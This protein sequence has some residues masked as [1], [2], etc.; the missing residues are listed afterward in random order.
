MTAADRPRFRPGRVS[1]T[2]AAPWSGVAEP[3]YDLVEYRETLVPL[4][5]ELPTRE[6]RILLMR[7]FGDMTQTEIG[8]QIG[9]SQMHVSRLLSRTLDQLRQQLVAD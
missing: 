6:R 2:D 9:I 1:E 4:L 3:Q 5:A 8:E 7:F